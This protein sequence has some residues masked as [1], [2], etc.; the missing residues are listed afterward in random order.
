MQN[1]EQTIGSQYA[2]SPVL[3]Q[4]INDF[5]QY[6][7]PAAN[8]TAF[9]DM[10]WN[11]S[12]AMGFGLTIWGN[13]LQVGRLLAVASAGPFFG[14]DQGGSMSGFGQGV[15]LEFVGETSI[16]SLPD[17]TYRTLL[18]TKALANISNMSIP[19][20]NQLVSNLFAGRGRC[21]CTDLGNMEM[22]YT[23]EFVLLPVE[24]A[25]LEQSGVLPHP[26]GVSVSIVQVP[27][28]SGVFGFDGSNLEPFNQGTFFNPSQVT[29]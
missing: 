17:S 21:Y 2:N 15:F 14:F 7:D 26:T 1:L 20:L 12:S 4:L 24:V 29:L 13:I 19:S 8:L 16:Y 3:L 28:S 5:N 10:V 23:F 27:V 9:Y 11:L 22:T 18:F 25:I 6:V